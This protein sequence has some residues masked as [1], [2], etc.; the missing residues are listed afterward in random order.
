[1]VGMGPTITRRGWAASLAASAIPA[2]ARPSQ[3]KAAAE[4]LLEQAKDGV[5][6]SA[7]KLQKF[8]LPMATEPAFLF[9]P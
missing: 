1:M 7:E 6:E 5:R 2:A 4:K 9:K 8:P 3:Q